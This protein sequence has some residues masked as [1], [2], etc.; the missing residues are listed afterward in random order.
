MLRYTI[1]LLFLLL[2]SGLSAQTLHSKKKKAVESYNQANELSRIG[3]LYESEQLLMAALKR[4]KSFDEAILLLHQIYLR[5]DEFEKSKEVWLKYQGE[6]DPNIQN[7]MLSDQANYQ[8]ELGKYQEAKS[9]ISPI[10]GPVYGLPDSIITMLVQSI[11]FALMQLRSP[12]SIDFEELPKPINEFKS[13]YFPSIT[14]SEQLVFTVRED[15]RHGG[16]NLYISSFID[17]GWTKPTQISSKINSDRNEGAASISLDGSTLVFTA[18]NLLDNI[19]SCDLYISYFKNNEWTEPEL[20]NARVNSPEWDSQPSLSR[21]GSRLYFVSRRPGGLGGAD[22]WVST[23]QKEGWSKAENLGAEINTKYD[24]LSP[25][26]YAD[27]KTLFFASKGR[28]GM[29]GLDLFVAQQAGDS[30]EVPKNLGYPINNAFDQ[31]GYSISPKGWAY[32]SSSKENG[33]ITLNRFKVPEEVVA[34]DEVMLIEGS[35]LDALTRVPVN[36][37][38]TLHNLD[39]NSPSSQLGTDKATGL[40]KL[41]VERDSMILTFEAENY[42]TRKLSVK[43]ISEL[44]NHEVLLQP[45]KSGETIQFGTINFDFASAE[46]KEESYPIL[47]EVIAFLKT[48]DSVIIEIGGHTDQIGEG[49]DNMVLSEDRARSVY[50]FLLKKGAAK[51]NLVYRGYGEDRPLRKGN[52]ENDRIKNRRIQFTIVGLLK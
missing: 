1:A 41:F 45:L 49:V 2:I 33:R 29:G 46:I 36:A 9:S 23:R 15:S 30:W 48:N 12:L 20:L 32:Y 10:Q 43:D 39:I 34:I 38:V 28:I 22:L 42:I 35:V 27:E 51:E 25:Y 13:Q 4:D 50:Q 17:G 6:L 40:F 16:E 26:I 14:F 7:R 3:N 18:C 24:D 21:D 47:D 19:G 8:Y 31:V 5:R 11:D 44:T 52:T 37:S